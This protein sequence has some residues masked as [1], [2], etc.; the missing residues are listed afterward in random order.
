MARLCLVVPMWQRHTLTNHLLTY[1][2][3][4]EVPGIETI[5]VVVG[6]EGNVSRWVARGLE[7]VETSNRPLDHKYDVGF[8]YC[9]QFEPDA[10]CLVGSDDFITE[11]Y[12]SWAMREV[13]HSADLLGLLE[14]HLADLSR[15]R[16]LYW[17]GYQGKRCGEPIAS[18]RIY[19]RR[20]LDAMDWAPH[21]G[22]EGY[23]DTVRDDERSFEHALRCGAGIQTTRMANIGCQFWAVKTGSELNH[24]AAFET[25]HRT[26]D[27]TAHAWKQF[28]LSVRLDAARIENDSPFGTWREAAVLA[29]ANRE[30]S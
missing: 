29:A 18:G 2:H 26:T 10:V 12:F 27:I 9:R 19:S 21:A 17:S 11:P 24:V 25:Y 16:I 20:L 15:R 5:V 7:Y 6:S 8:K 13:A 1:Y 4:L 3:A 23:A 28:E 22:P 14:L 30:A